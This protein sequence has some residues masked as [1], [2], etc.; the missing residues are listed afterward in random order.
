MN[1]ELESRREMEMEKNKQKR[2]QID[3]NG[4]ITTKGSKFFSA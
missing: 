2:H 3:K 4:N 1:K